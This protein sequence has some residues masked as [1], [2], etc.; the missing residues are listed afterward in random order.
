M[1]DFEA[2]DDYSNPG[3]ILLIESSPLQE[4]WNSFVMNSYVALTASKVESVSSKGAATTDREDMESRLNMITA[5]SK[6]GKYTAEIPSSS[7]SS[8]PSS[9]HGKEDDS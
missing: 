8:S 5:D 1:K 2:R 3:S 6:A 4:T 7:T 9:H